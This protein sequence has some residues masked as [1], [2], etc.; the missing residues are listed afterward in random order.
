MIDDEVRNIEVEQMSRKSACLRLG[1]SLCLVSLTAVGCSLED[2]CDYECTD[3]SV[4]IKMVKDKV[5]CYVCKR[6]TDGCTKE[7][8]ASDQAGCM[9]IY[10]SQNSG[11]GDR[12]VTDCDVCQVSREE[13]DLASMIYRYCTRDAET[14]CAGW[15]EDSSQFAEKCKSDEK[16]KNE[17]VFGQSECIEKEQVYRYCSKN[18]KTGCFSWVSSSEKYE[19]S[20]SSGGEPTIEC[21]NPCSANDT[22]CLTESKSYRSCQKDEETGCYFWKEEK[23]KY[24][25]LCRSC[26]DECEQGKIFCDDD[27]RSYD[28]CVFNAE[29]DCYEW[30][31]DDSLYKEK[32]VKCDTGCE[33]GVRKMK[34]GACK[35]CVTDENECTFWDKAPLFDNYQLMSTSTTGGVKLLVDVNPDNGDILVAWFSIEGERLG[36]NLESMTKEGCALWKRSLYFNGTYTPA[37]IGNTN[38]LIGDSNNIFIVWG[39]F[40]SMDES[41]PKNWQ[42]PF[43]HLSMEQLTSETGLPISIYSNGTA[44]L[45]NPSAALVSNQQFSLCSEHLPLDEAGAE[46]GMKFIHC[47][48]DGDSNLQGFA[49]PNDELLVGTYQT[50]PRL[51]IN[52]DNQLVVVWQE[53]TNKESRSYVRYSVLNDPTKIVSFG[54]MDFFEIE[55]V[56]QIQTNPAL[57][58]G[59]S[60]SMLVVYEENSS[61]PEKPSSKIGGYVY[62]KINGSTNYLKSTDH[63]LI[64]DGNNPHSPNACYLKNG[65]GIVVYSTDSN[66]GDVMYNKINGGIVSEATPISSSVDGAQL[67]H[68]LACFD[69]R[70]ITAYL[71]DPDGDGKY[72]VML[73]QIELK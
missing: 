40:D 26:K 17:C 52:E 41:Q 6:Q 20:C 38:L 1:L 13:C 56:R 65:T 71:D 59:A 50:N 10:D 60:K 35:L 23:G 11:E 67:S 46:R 7:M 5:T 62:Q 15:V 51:A 66:N 8:L 69:N 14:M 55:G 4:S 54:S 31:H 34:D 21:S 29:T 32:C 48:I 37:D 27:N 39:A 53:V 57:A 72:N 2:P 44:S 70:F 49:T 36:L 33:V 16:C 9:A 61:D 12:K 22:E 30:H 25:D 3:Q 28:T 47:L 19:A 42:L 18:E 45:K 63:L 73:K 68:T 43:M 64:A 58:L 24:K